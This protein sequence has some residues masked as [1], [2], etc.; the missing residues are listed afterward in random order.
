[1]SLEPTLR[2]MLTPWRAA[3]FVQDPG[4]ILLELALAVAV[5]G[6]CATD[7]SVLRAEPAVFGPVPRTRP[8]PG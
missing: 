8:S 1:M 4:N 2:E 3:R 7:I 6:D 5:D